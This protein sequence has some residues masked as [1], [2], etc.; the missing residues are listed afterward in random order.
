MIPK[1]IHDFQREINPGYTKEDSEAIR[2]GVN[3]LIDALYL[4]VADS[5]L[6]RI[7]DKKRLEHFEIND[8]SEPINWGDLNCSTVE[9]NGQDAW[10]VTIDEA[11]PGDCPTLCAYIERHMNAYGWNIEVLTEW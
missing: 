9:A 10:E 2:E 4:P 3:H 5:Q 8:K 6:I 7:V 11:G 1:D